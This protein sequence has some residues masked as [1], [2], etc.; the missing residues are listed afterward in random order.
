MPNDLARIVGQNVL[1]VQRLQA[2][3]TSGAGNPNVVFLNEYGQFTDATPTVT[4]SLALDS[5][6]ANLSRCNP[7]LLHDSKDETQEAI[8]IGTQYG[9]PIFTIPFA[10]IGSFLGNWQTYCGSWRNFYFTAVLPGGTS[11]YIYILDAS[12]NTVLKSGNTSPIDISSVSTTR[13]IRPMIILTSSGA[14][15]T[16]QN[17]TFTYDGSRTGDYGS[18]FV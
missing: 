6:I 9:A 10:G 1:D 4:N 12:G 18:A 7:T 8:L 5:I 15:P 17:Y 13:Q 14:L 3:N 2:E 16:F 11:T